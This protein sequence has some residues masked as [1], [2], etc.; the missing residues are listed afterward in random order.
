MDSSLAQ[1]YLDDDAFFALFDLICKHYAPIWQSLSIP[2]GCS[3]AHNARMQ[4]P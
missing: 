3:A 2:K 1:S 4:N